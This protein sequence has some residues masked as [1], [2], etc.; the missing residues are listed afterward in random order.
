[1]I[2]PPPPTDMKGNSDFV[3]P[4]DVEPLENIDPMDPMELDNLD[5]PKIE[6]AQMNEPEI[7]DIDLD[8]EPEVINE[9]TEIQTKPAATLSEFHQMIETAKIRKIKSIE[10]TAKVIA[11]YNGGKKP[12]CGY[13]IYHNVFVYLPGEKHIAETRD[14]RTMEQVL[15]SQSTV[16]IKDF[17]RPQY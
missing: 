11:H 6:S 14:A 9:E 1:M 8:Q 10:A 2:Q 3:L 12:E 4:K 7:D 15:F 16:Q 13:I 17:E 5:N